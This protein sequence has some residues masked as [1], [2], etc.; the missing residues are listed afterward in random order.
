MGLKENFEKKVQAEEEALKKEIEELESKIKEKE[1]N[2]KDDILHPIKTAKSRKEIDELKE[3]LEIAKSKVGNVAKNKKTTLII[4]VVFVCLFIATFTFIFVNAKKEGEEK[5]VQETAQQIENAML[6]EAPSSV[7]NNYEKA[8]FNELNSPASE[9]GLG[10]SMV[11]VNGIY[12]EVTTFENSGFE[13]YQAVLTDRDENKWSIWL[14]VSGLDEL[15]TYQNLA[16]Q[17]LCVLANYQGYSE[18]NKM[19]SLYV[20]EIYNKLTGET[21]DTNYYK[22]LLNSNEVSEIYT[23]DRVKMPSLVGLPVAKAKTSLD[24]NGI[25]NYVF[26]DENG[27]PLESDENYYVKTQSID[28]GKSILK[29]TEIVLTCEYKEPQVKETPSTNNN[30][31]SSSTTTKTDALAYVLRTSDYY[32]YIYIDENAGYIYMFDP[33]DDVA[34]RFKIESGD[35]NSTLIASIGSRQYGFCYKWKNQ[36]SRLIFDDGSGY[37][38]EYTSSDEKSVKKMLDE[39]TIVD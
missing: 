8:S 28:Q 9:N 29:T 22:D 23:S 21:F 11:Y 19:P 16:G 10:G 30:S 3:D 31:N 20:K 33:E 25:D 12:D 13:Y 27:S 32:S 15:E 38:D 35:L 24:S 14:G 2:H 5:A 34:Q 1:A 26:N 18:T 36:P 4:V 7:T 39:K 6:T 37:T 17:P